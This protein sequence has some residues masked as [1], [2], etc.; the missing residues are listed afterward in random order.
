MAAYRWNLPIRSMMRL[1]KAEM[2]KRK[3]LNIF[4]L[5]SK[6]L[7]YATLICEGIKKMSSV[8]KEKK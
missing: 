2:T 8:F 7:I 4:L 1:I 5:W 6:I 3:C